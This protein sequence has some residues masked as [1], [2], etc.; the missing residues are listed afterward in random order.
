MNKRRIAGCIGFT[1]YGGA[2][3]VAGAG[4][5]V[6][7]KQV[8]DLSK[9]L[10]YIATVSGTSAGIVQTVANTTIGKNFDATPWDQVGKLVIFPGVSGKLKA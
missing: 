10:M 7:P 4:E 1:I 9:G 5:A 2:T 6:N 8:N 3:A